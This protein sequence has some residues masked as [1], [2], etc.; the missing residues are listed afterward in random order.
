M[1]PSLYPENRSEASDGNSSTSALSAG[2]TFTGVSKWLW[3][4]VGKPGGGSPKVNI[5]GRVYNRNVDTFY[6]IFAAIVDTTS[7]TTLSIT[8]PVSFNLSPTDVLFFE[9][10]TDTNSTDIHLRFS[11]NVYENQ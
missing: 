1:I 11:L 9:A 10:D 4:N 6:N 3:I 2:A 5:R 8:D 7:E